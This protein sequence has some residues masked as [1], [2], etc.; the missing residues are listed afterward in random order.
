MLCSVQRYSG[1]RFSKD[2]FR[3][4]VLL[5]QIVLIAGYCSACSKKQSPPTGT[6]L[7]SG[8]K[9]FGALP[10]TAVEPVD[11]YSTYRLPR[12]PESPAGPLGRYISKLPIFT[13]AQ[14]LG[15]NSR[16]ALRAWQSIDSVA[17]LS[18]ELDF[19][20]S[21]EVEFNGDKASA[22]N[23][24]LSQSSV[25]ALRVTSKSISVDEPISIV[26]TDIRLD[27]S[28][29]VIRSSSDLHYLVRIENANRVDVHGG[30]FSGGD[31][32]FLINHS[33]HVRIFNA[34]IRDLAGAGIVVT[35]SKVIVVRG[36][37][38]S[39]LKLAGVIL[40]RGVSGSLVEQNRIENNLG[41]A[42]LAAAIVLTDREID[43]AS[44]PRAIFGP[45]AYSVQQRLEIRRH[46]PSGNFIRANELLRNRS[47]GLFS[48]GGVRNVIASNEIAGNAKEGICLDDASTANLVT[49][50]AVR[51]NGARWAE[52]ELSP[53]RE[54]NEVESGLADGTPAAKLPGISL[55]NALYNVLFENDIAENYGGGIKLV[56]TGLFNVI[57]MNT[58]RDNAMGMSSIIHFFGIELGAAPADLSTRELAIT[59]SRGNL[60]FSNIIRGH[61]YAGIFFGDGSDQNN[62]FDNVIMDAT[63]WALESVRLLENTAM[64]NLTN[65][66]SRNIGPGL[67]PNL[68]VIGRPVMDAV[69]G[70]SNEVLN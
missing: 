25:K 63:C 68:F 21:G 36:N 18:R 40:H 17:S 8:A 43:I 58:L 46:P 7:T 33:E 11:I 2:R 13:R 65:L 41:S 48:D 32:A 28:T 37:H 64:N 39:R 57:G 51:R 60:I 59:P 61:Y 6:A 1:T 4:T 52:S 16:S 34:T 26:R 19:S 23:R 14:N 53:A 24:L 45:D 70:T 30:V 62:V 66:P 50:N 9:Q 55:D 56:R 3:Q 67:D 38:I 42:N 10:P 54:T 35:D 31:S 12:L 44:N 49:A 69:D 15:L 47:A 5:L 27:L 22:L 29:A 20:P